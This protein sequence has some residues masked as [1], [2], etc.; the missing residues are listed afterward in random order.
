MLTENDDLDFSDY[1]EYD[2]SYSKYVK[3]TFTE[4]SVIGINEGDFR[5]EGRKMREE[6]S[7]LAA[8]STENVNNFFR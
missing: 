6:G 1:Q 4:K 2:E 7:F 8:E 3:E 5:N